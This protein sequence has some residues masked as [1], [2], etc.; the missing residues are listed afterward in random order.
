MTDVEKEAAEKFG[1]T[2]ANWDNESGFEEQP[3]LMHV[4]WAELKGNMRKALIVLGWRR[5]SWDARKPPSA[6][7]VFFLRTL[8]E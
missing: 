1:F 8:Q 4:L 6:N 3:A 2:E 7:K 5:A